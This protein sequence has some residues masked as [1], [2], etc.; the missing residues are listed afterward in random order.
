MVS[1]QVGGGEIVQ[2]IW[3]ELKSLG[4]K[5]QAVMQPYV[6]SIGAAIQ[7]NGSVGLMKESMYSNISNAGGFSKDLDAQ[8]VRNEFD[9]IYEASVFNI[10]RFINTNIPAL[11]VTGAPFTLSFNGSSLL[12]KTD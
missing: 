2:A 11:L 6:S 7:S 1:S 12:I 5:S 9:R 10:T 4:V 3:F 8:F